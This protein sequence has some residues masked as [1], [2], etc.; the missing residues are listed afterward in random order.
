MIGLFELLSI[1][2]ANSHYRLLPTHTISKFLEFQISFRIILSSTQINASPLLSTTFIQL[3]DQ[4]TIM[5][6][7]LTCK[8]WSTP[9]KHVLLPKK[10]D[11]GARLLNYCQNPSGLL[12]QVFLYHPKDVDE[13]YVGQKATRNETCSRSDIESGSSFCE[14]RF[15]I[16]Q[17]YYMLIQ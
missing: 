7:E 1:A 14:A 11:I 15:L 17:L 13:I 6:N 8:W 4:S 2:H 12:S 10:S 16:I 5:F 3:F 9:Q